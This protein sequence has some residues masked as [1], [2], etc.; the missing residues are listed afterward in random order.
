M[1]R[2]QS[3]LRDILDR[4]VKSFS[5]KE[6]DE[7]LAK[8]VTVSYEQCFDRNL[9]RKIFTG[10]VRRAENALYPARGKGRNCLEDGQAWRSGRWN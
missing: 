3:L 4:A 7:I 5:R 1:G 2:D 6:R 9:V 8:W 10:V